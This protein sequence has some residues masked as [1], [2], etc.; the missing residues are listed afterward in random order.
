MTKHLQIFAFCVLLFAVPI[1]AEEVDAPPEGALV[2]E[3]LDEVLVSGEQPGP[4]LWQVRH[5]DHVLWILG[6]LAPLPAKVRW[7]SRQVESVIS[8]A[9]EVLVVAGIGEG[10]T[11]K[12]PNPDKA[13]KK[14]ILAMMKGRRLPGRQTLKDVLSPETYARFKVAKRRFAKND[15]EIERLIPSDAN[16]R[17]L[18]SAIGTLGL[19]PASQPASTVVFRL[20]QK[21]NIKISHVVQLGP[22]SRPSQDDQDIR[23]HCPPLDALL[24]QLEDGGA[25]W[26]ALANAWSVGNID[27]LRRLVPAHAVL[28]GLSDRCTSAL[29]GGEQQHKEAVAAKAGLVGCCRARLAI[30][31]H[32]LGRSADGGTICARWA[33]LPIARP[34]IRNY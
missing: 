15:G 21:A 33:R 12:P 29:Y 25:G 4:L 2:L 19:S 3:V 31:S 17:L 9:Q 28:T 24:G 13:T 5:Q 30:Q 23:S 34:R 20:A 11:N 22:K 32:D 26:K 7:R 16:T 14:E 27:A 10:L 8:D 6:E 1:L 18:G